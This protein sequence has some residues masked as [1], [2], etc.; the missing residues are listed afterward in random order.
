MRSY[1]FCHTNTKNPGNNL[2]IFCLITGRPK[3]NGY[4]QGLSLSTT[5][6]SYS[7]EM[8]RFNLFRDQ[9]LAALNFVLTIIYNV[10]GHSRIRKDFFSIWSRDH[11]ANHKN[12]KILFFTSE[13]SRNCLRS[14]SW[15]SQKD[16]K[17][18][19]RSTCGETL[20]DFSCKRSLWRVIYKIEA[21]KFCRI[22]KIHS[23]WP[24]K[25]Q[26]WYLLLVRTTDELIF[27]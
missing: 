9:L 20:F 24:M 16:T 3:L 22:L 21:R 11:F 15:P 4:H 26:Q 10:F 27:I 18:L 17:I 13:T 2:G 14:V 25:G 6:N 7:A 5:V 8:L 19:L 12:H 23:N 1:N